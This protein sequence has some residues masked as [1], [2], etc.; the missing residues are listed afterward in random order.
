MANPL[1]ARTMVELA[2][3]LAPPRVGRVLLLS[4]LR[5]G[6]EWI[7]DDVPQTLEVSQEVMRRAIPEAVR[8]DMLMDGLTT[9][10][11]EPWDE[12]ARVAG[13][14]RPET[15]L[16]GLSDLDT[17]AVRLP[18]ERVIAQVDAD[19]VVLGSPAGWGLDHVRRIL[20]LV[21]GTGAHVQLRARLLGGLCRSA[22]REIVFLRVVPA[23][24]SEHERSR[25]ERQLRGEAAEEVPAGATARVVADDDFLAIA[26]AHA[27]ES[28]LVIV[29]TQRGG[30]RRVI[31]DVARRIAKATPGGIILLRRRD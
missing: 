5:P 9:I 14:R 12:I 3:A 10:A 16:L 29:G 19:T 11:D 23:S 25:S 30:G 15:L 26:M 4:V 22:P 20:V 18:V 28:D 1:R 6:D 17:D 7:A 31:G 13:F 2:D 27:A 8:R 21:A 24:T